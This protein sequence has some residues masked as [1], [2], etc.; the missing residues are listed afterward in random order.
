MKI[1]KENPSKNFR[2]CWKTKKKNY[3]PQG[4]FLW[5]FFFFI[6]IKSS[7]KKRLGFYPSP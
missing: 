6:L 3:Y 5:G 7:L 1:F 2:L 4:I